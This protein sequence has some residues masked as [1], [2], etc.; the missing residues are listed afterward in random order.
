MSLSI[1]SL[2]EKQAIEKALAN[3]EA[4]QSIVFRK[5]LAGLKGHDVSSLTKEDYTQ[6]SDYIVTQKMRTPESRIKGFNS[7]RKR[8]DSLKPRCFLRLIKGQALT[9]K[10]MIHSLFK[11]Y[12][13]I[14]IP[15]LCVLL[16]TCDRYWIFGAIRPSTTFIHL[17]IL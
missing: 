12:G 10:N 6:L 7:L 16:K 17:I 8:R 2:G 4:E 9:R 5:L 15:E 3:S 11:S 13:L 1:S 14:K